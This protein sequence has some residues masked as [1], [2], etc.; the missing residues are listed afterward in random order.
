VELQIEGS[1][2]EIWYQQAN[3][4][5]APKADHYSALANADFCQKQ[6][7]LAIKVGK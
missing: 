4:R 2:C 1:T 6:N 3:R 5:T 7:A